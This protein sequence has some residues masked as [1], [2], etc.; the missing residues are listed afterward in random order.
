MGS[1]ASEA[2][3]RQLRSHVREAGRDHITNG[4]GKRVGPRAGHILGNGSWKC[5]LE[6]TQLFMEET[7]KEL[8]KKTCQL[9]RVKIKRE[10]H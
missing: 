10:M 7:Q 4:W 3:P 2:G 6:L 9:I 8:E 5:P 1:R